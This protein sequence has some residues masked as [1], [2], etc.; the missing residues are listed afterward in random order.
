MKLGNYLLFRFSFLFVFGLCLAVKQTLFKDI[1][2]SYIQKETNF[3]PYKY[4]IFDTT[5]AH[6]SL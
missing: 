4:K 2:L 1:L 6:I 5:N 3:C